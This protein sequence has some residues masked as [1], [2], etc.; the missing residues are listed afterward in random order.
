MSLVPEWPA[1][2]ASM[3][4]QRCRSTLDSIM[5]GCQVLGFDWRYLYLN[6]AAAAQNRRPN[7]EL[8]GRTILECW[9]GIEHTPVFGMLRRTMEERVALQSEVEF[10]FPDG[11]VG[12][13]EVRGQPVPEGLFILSIDISARHAHKV[14]LERL[15]RLYD[16]LS[17]VNQAIVR[18]PAREALFREVC[19]I[20]VD[21]GGFAMAWIGCPDSRGG[22][23]LPVASA[24]A[25]PQQLD[26]I[27]IRLDDTPEGRG[28]TGRALRERQVCVCNDV[29]ADPATYP[30]RAEYERHGYRASAAF[31]IIVDGEPAGVLSVY[32]REKNCFQARELALLQEAVTDVGFALEIAAREQEREQAQRQVQAERRFSDSMIESLP[33]VAYFYDEAGHFLRWNRNFLL[34]TGYDSE[35][36][37]TMHPRD[38]FLGEDRIRVEQAIAATFEKGEAAVQAGFVARDGGVTPYYFTGRRLVIDGQQY[39]VGVG[40]DVSARTLAEAEVRRLNAELESRI[41]ERTAQLEAANAELESFSYSVSH[42]LRAPLRAINGFS[43]ILLEDF[44][45]Q[46]PEEAASHL[47]RIREAGR[48]MG[49]LIDDLLNLSRLGRVPM[50]RG[51]VDMTALARGAVQDLEQQYRGRRINFRIAE[52]PPCTG[53][54]SVLQQVWINL[55]SNAVKYTRDRDPAQVDIDCVVRDGMPI[56]S[57]RDNGTGFD[58]RYAGKLFGVFQ[59]LHRSDQFEGTGVGLAIVRRVLARHGGRIWAEAAVDRGAT[60]HFTV[61]GGPEQ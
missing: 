28:P 15:T 3:L 20:V 31:P 45:A 41:R 8:L 50:I 13:F 23:L 2:S 30:W 1:P 40:I 5:E 6:D 22:Q 39:L 52:L 44:A 9:P 37:A 46:L 34:V 53:D 4:E 33:G 55:V 12:H 24:G 18:R 48:R 36:M 49:A 51:P 56:Y 38:F 32:S 19:R 26:A 7:S 27:R 11:T 58:M 25:A 10:T 43:D 60:F 14:E 42:D 61:K 57:V 16:A 21:H 59:R 54:A 47:Q 17:H 29:F 35:A